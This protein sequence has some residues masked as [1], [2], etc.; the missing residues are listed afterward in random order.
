MRG[1]LHD[2]LA[3]HLP[4]DRLEQAP[5]PWRFAPMPG[6]R[7]TVLT[8]PGATRHL[9]E[10]QR[11]GVTAEGYDESGFLRLSVPL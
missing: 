4:T 11:A 3:G 5:H 8:G 9:H 10:V 1:A 7:V 2:Y 6:T